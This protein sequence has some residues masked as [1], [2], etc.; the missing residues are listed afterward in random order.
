MRYHRRRRD[1]ETERENGKREK[2]WS[3]VAIES[4]ITCHFAI[5]FSLFL[6]LSVSFSTLFRSF[7][8][9]NVIENFHKWA[10]HQKRVDY[11]VRLHFS[12][13]F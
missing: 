4:E 12:V 10:E 3:T 8:D 2:L 6:G 1:A 9:H 7:Y 13:S 11:T 5:V